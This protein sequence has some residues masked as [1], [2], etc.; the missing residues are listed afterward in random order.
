MNSF[1]ES[2]RRGFS[3]TE[4]LVVVA[5]IVI[6]ASL[7]TPA[8]NA[9]KGGGDVTSA[10]YDIAGSLQAA[11][12]Y[13]IANNTYTWVGFYEEDA[14]KSDPTSGAPPYAGKGKV[15][16][17]VIASDDGTKLGDASEVGSKP[18][19]PEN[20]TPISKLI[21]VTGVHLTEL[22]SPSGG[23]EGASLDDRPP[24]DL[25]G[26][27]ANGNRISS[28]SSDQTASPFEV[29]DYTFYKTIRFSPRGEVNVNDTGSSPRV[30][31]IGLRP[32]RGNV[33]DQN[34]PN[35]VAIQ[36]TGIGGRVNVY[37]K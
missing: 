8:F 35:V 4:L 29:Q 11:R 14:N 15:V 25:T 18:M 9:I 31:E 6:M 33:V 28:D 21:K 12:A 17:G 30:A 5:I 27:A 7:A 34:T 2:D 32:V 3:L 16:I 22:D 24:V 26:G 23:Q 1:V 37:R 13:A 36:L 20:Y 19:D 10:A